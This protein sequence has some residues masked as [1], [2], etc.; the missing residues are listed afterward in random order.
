MKPL[1]VLWRLIKGEDV[2]GLSRY[3]ERLDALE[4]QTEDLELRM[5]AQ[6]GIRRIAGES[7]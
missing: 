2:L 6:E 1:Q 5:S 3:G 7:R 4:R